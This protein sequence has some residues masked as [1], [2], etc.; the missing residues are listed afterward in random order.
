MSRKPNKST[1]EMMRVTFLLPG[2]LV[3]KLD[4]IATAKTKELNL[5][6]TRSDIARQAIDKFM[7][8]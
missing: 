7:D 4:A 3:A 2:D 5:N 8:R 1:N 6:V